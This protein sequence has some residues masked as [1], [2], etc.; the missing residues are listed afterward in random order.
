VLRFIRSKTLVGSNSYVS[1][2]WTGHWGFGC[3]CVCVCV[4]MLLF[5]C[6]LEIIFFGRLNSKDHYVIVCVCVC[7]CVCVQ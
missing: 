4:H 2:C 5:C 6:P 1:Y 3:V 7:V